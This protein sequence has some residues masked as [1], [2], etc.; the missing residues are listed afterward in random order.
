MVHAIPVRQP[1]SRKETAVTDHTQNVNADAESDT[2]IGDEL[3][4]ESE[5]GTSKALLIE[6]IV[7][8]EI[9]K[10][11]SRDEFVTAVAERV[12]A[13]YTE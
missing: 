10:G 4:M 8:T 9:Q 2:P 6:E 12:E 1:S 5:P 3:E 11:G 13:L 7:H